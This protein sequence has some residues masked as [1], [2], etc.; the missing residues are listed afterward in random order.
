MGKGRRGKILVWVA[1][2]AGVGSGTIIK[3]QADDVIKAQGLAK[4]VEVEAVSEN[5]AKCEACDILLCT[6]NISKRLSKRLSI[7]V[8]GLKNVMSDKEYEDKLIPV[9][10]QLLEQEARSSD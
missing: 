7:P 3:L 6:L 8:V 2:P 10:Q 1:C 4:K 9:I 5:L